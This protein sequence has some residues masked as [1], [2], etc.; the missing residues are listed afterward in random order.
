MMTIKIKQFN[1]LSH[2]LEVAGRLQLVDTMALGLA[3]GAA[4]GHRAFASTTANTD[5]EDH[6]A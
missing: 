2:S 3:I 4:L 5:S 1:H 6:K